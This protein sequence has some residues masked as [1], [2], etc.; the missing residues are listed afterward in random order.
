MYLARMLP[1]KKFAAWWLMLAA[2]VIFLA[3]GIFAFVDPL[4][5]YLK[6]VKFTGI[7]LLVNGG[8]L[9]TMVILQSKYPNERKW[10]QAES[11]LHL[12][13]G[14]LFLFNP[15]LA[16]IALPYF[17]GVWVLLVGILKIFAAL[18][19]R[20]TVRGWLFILLVGALCALFGLLLLF[21]P[22]PKATGIT[23]L[24]GV[25]GLIMGAL[26]TFDAYRFRKKAETL[27]MML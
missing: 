16:F 25:F 20:R 23:M 2:G 22:L 12:F 13:F 17:I 26:Y 3:I 24:I 21:I 8:I 10:M 15:L 7:A 27:N 4:T 6:L 11:I 1:S 14:I 19:L 5:S 9:L 18:S